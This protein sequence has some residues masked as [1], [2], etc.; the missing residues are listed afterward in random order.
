MRGAR[1]P[2]PHELLDVAF[3]PTEDAREFCYLDER[4]LT[5]HL[6]FDTT[7]KVSL[8]PAKIASRPVKACQRFTITS[9]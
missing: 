7:A 8:V 4:Q 1:H 5:P 3:G 2:S 9:Q 6:F